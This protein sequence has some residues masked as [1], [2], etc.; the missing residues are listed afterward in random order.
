MADVAGLAAPGTGGPN[1]RGT[2]TVA[3][4][5]IVKIAEQAARLTSPRV[6][7]ALAGTKLPALEVAVTKNSAR[8]RARVAAPWAAPAAVSAG[9]VADRI[10]SDLLRYADTSAEL[11]EVEVAEFV[12][13]EG[14]R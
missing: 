9:A 7:G 4:R 10:R 3:D 13:V 11:V 6:G 2:T 5:V 14:P 8:V 1:E 12:H